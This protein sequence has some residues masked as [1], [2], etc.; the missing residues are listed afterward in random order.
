MLCCKTWQKLLRYW[1]PKAEKYH[2]VHSLLEKTRKAKEIL[3]KE[4]NQKMKST[5]N[6][7]NTFWYV[8]SSQ[9]MVQGEIY[10]YHFVHILKK[11]YKNDP[12]FQITLNYSASCNVVM[13]W[14]WNMFSDVILYLK[15]M[16]DFIFI[17]VSSNQ[18]NNS[19]FQDTRIKNILKS[20]LPLKPP[21]NLTRHRPHNQDFILFLLFQYSCYMSD[22]V[23]F[24]TKIS[25]F[26]SNF[27]LCH[28]YLTRN[29]IY[30][31]NDL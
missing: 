19:G 14:N 3:E 12:A 21:I 7:Q 27:L 11:K 9:H 20:E 4:Q 16:R 6:C 25:F 5:Y 28:C 26:Q 29:K 22:M 13:F 8:F 10:T 24:T 31:P 18:E 30:V 15:M 17:Q 1:S 23:L 2:R